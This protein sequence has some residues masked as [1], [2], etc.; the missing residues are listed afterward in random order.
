MMINEN[1]IDDMYAIVI[2]IELY[3]LGCLFAG[4][5]FGN[6]SNYRGNS[7]QISLKIYNLGFFPKSS[8]II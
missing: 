6:Y 5:N 4:F 1:W 3:C 8:R 2:V 7:A